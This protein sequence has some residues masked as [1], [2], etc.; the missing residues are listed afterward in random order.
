[1]AI[2]FSRS[3]RSL[4][5]DD[6]RRS[7]WGL[8]LAGALL[9]AWTL[10]FILSRVSIYEVT[11]A[12]RLE[13]DRSAHPVEAPVQGRIISHHLAMG[14]QVNEGNLLVEL[15]AHALELELEEKRKQLL[16]LISQREALHKESGSKELS[17]QDQ[18]Q[19]GRAAVSELRAQFE[20]AQAA[21][22]FAEAQAERMERLHEDGLI[23]RATLD[24]A[25]TEAHRRRALAQSLGSSLE[26]EQLQRRQESTEHRAVIDRLMG[27]LAR[28][29]GE[30][31]A[32]SDHVERLQYEIERRHVRAP[33]DGWLGEIAE[34]QVGS[35]VEEGEKLATVIPSGELKIVAFFPPAAAL[36]R[37]QPGQQARLR[38]EGFP[39]T[40]YGS[41]PAVVAKVASEPRQRR[42]RVELG[43][44]EGISSRILLQHGLPGAV[45]VEVDRVSPAT[46]VLRAA[47]SLLSVPL[48]TPE[49]EG[50]GEASQ[51]AVR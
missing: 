49:S 11:D 14:R 47:G 43:L 32:T 18:I 40:Q 23:A 20:E 19:S 16:S 4:Q 51:Q 29:E 30:I 31:T 38:L 50:S 13:A 22:A 7:A 25:R 36:G 39:W 17:G 5:A 27:E 33:V 41:V 35:F 26:R 24:E 45:E 42:V 2:P 15:D 10:W 9:L 1:M 28:L 44:G 3:M 21:A 6:F 46:L 48:V 12:A 8:A 37:I 34:V